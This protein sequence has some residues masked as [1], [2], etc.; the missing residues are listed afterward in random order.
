VS[1][2]S[3]SSS[4]Q[5]T[6]GEVSTLTGIKPGRIRHYED[7]GL[8]A[9][10][11]EHSG[12]RS[13]GADDVLRLLYIDLLR[14][15]GMGLEAIR[16]SLAADP[17]DLRGALSHHVAALRSEREALDRIIGIV[18]EALAATESADSN[19]VLVGRMARMQRTSLGNF[20][21][22][23]SALSPDAELAL[24][25][26]LVEG[27]N[28][29]VPDLFGQMLLPGAVTDLLDRLVRAEGHE[30]LFERLRQLADEI[31]ALDE[32]PAALEQAER[33]ARNWVRE[34]VDDP[35]PPEVA[36]VLREAGPLVAD[37]PVIGAGFLLWAEAVSP[38]A[39]VAFRAMAAEARRRRVRIIGAIVIP[40]APKA[41]PAS[42]V[43]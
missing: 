29:P 17:G 1:S 31:V 37:L 20:G 16:R 4:S 39:A 12:Y 7:K 38:A 24:D 15:S 18:E 33:L 35:M 21:R 32:G 2:H 27:W 34:Q 8:V 36:V 41:P 6:I 28:V 10:H 43:S 11:H 25:R 22:L 13:F 40:P 30:S 9:P 19:D 14:R 26:L 23:A 42:G 5:L 3:A